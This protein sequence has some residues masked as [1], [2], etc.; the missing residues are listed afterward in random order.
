MESFVSTQKVAVQKGLS[1]KLAK[2]VTC[3]GDHVEL[4]MAALQALVR[5]QMRLDALDPRR[6]G[7]PLPPSVTITMGCAPPPPPSFQQ[8]LAGRPPALPSQQWLAGRGREGSC[9]RP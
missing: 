7:A 4:L 2:F 3:K 6:D 9:C 1:R 5:A 8:W